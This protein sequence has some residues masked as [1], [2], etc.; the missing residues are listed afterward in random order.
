[1]AMNIVAQRYPYAQSFQQKPWRSPEQIIT[2]PSCRNVQQQK[3]SQKKNL[4]AAL[5]EKVL[6]FFSQDVPEAS[7]RSHQQNIDHT[8]ISV[9][10]HNAAATTLVD[11]TPIRMPSARCSCGHQ[12]EFD[13]QFCGGCGV[14]LRT[15]IVRERGKTRC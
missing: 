11:L 5:K 15:R 8:W 10:T 2:L 14:E 4:F 1:M 13:N 12:L 6:A 9:S 7:S 3:H